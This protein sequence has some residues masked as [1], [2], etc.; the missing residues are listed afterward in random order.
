[1]FEHV[2]FDKLKDITKKV[3]PYRG[4]NNHYPV[5]PHYRHQSYKRFFAHGKL[6]DLAD[7]NKEA[8]IIEY[9]GR[10]LIVVNEDNV[11]EFLQDHYYQGDR[12]FLTQLCD[13]PSGYYRQGWW[14]EGQLVC[15]DERRGG[16]VWVNVLDAKGHYAQ[17]RPIHPKI[18]YNMLTNEPLVAYD[19][20][21]PRV[22]RTKNIDITDKL[23]SVFKQVETFWRAS[24]DKFH[25]SVQELVK[26]GKAKYGDHS[27]RNAYE[28]MYERGEIDLLSAIILDTEYSY[29]VWHDSKNVEGAIKGVKQKLKEMIWEWEQAYNESITPCELAYIPTNDRLQVRMRGEK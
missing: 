9:Q 28:T 16:N 7:N 1:M 15:N 29:W 10:P 18:R 26:E 23:N 14:H 4:S 8:F 22:D 21:S 5:F 12:M 11:V 2:T 6:Y 17:F 20:I 19:I 24:G 25:E 3:K 13:N 27:W